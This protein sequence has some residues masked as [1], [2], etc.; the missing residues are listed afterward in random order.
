VAATSAPAQQLVRQPHAERLQI[1]LH[2]LQ[3]HVDVTPGNLND[4]PYVY[5][6]WSDF[7]Y[8]ALY[9]S[10][11]ISRL[12]ILDRTLRGDERPYADDWPIE[13]MPAMPVAFDLQLDSGRG[14]FDFT[15]M[16]VRDLDVIATSSDLSFDIRS[17]NRV[18]LE[19][20]HLTVQAG[21]LQFHHLLNANAHR[22]RL[23]LPRTNS[24]IELTGQP[25]AGE[26]LIDFEARP[27]SL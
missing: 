14:K 16:S 8:V 13:L 12:V 20:A 25:P 2:S 6:S 5:R 21:D 3:D 15:G 11:V 17:P 7:P 27:G 24:R 18:H 19:E 23:D 9:E 1:E 10:N 26:T 22:F 4:P